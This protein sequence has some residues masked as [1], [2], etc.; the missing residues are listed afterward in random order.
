MT[1]CSGLTPRLTEQ[2]RNGVGSGMVSAAGE[3]PPPSRVPADQRPL[4]PSSLAMSMRWTSLVPSPISR[5]LAS[6]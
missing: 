4:R 6:R 3:W 1:A 5:I 2:G